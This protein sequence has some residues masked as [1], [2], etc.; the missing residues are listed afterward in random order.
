MNPSFSLANKVA[1]VTGASRWTGRVIAL[2]LAK[3]G[4]DVVVAARTAEEIEKAVAE[5]RGLGRR[6]LAVQTDWCRAAGN[7]GD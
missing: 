1:I 7:K 2:E 5:I 3:A 6:S 4:A